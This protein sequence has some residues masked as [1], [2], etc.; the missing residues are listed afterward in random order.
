ML[1]HCQAAGNGDVDWIQV[2]EINGEKLWLTDDGGVVTA[3]LPEDC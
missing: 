2:P 1:V 3:L